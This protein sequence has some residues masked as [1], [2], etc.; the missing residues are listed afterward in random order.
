MVKAIRFHK[1]G[2]PEVMRLEDVDL[3]APA[4]GEVQVKHTAIGLNYIDTYHR[5]GLYPL[6]MPHGLGMEGAGTVAA[7]GGGV[8]DLKVGDRIAYAAPPPGSY[9]EARN[10]EASK[11]VKV[12]DGV[13]DKTAAAMMLKGMTAQYLI[14]Q[15]YKVQSGDTILIHAAAGGVGLIVSQWAKALGA[16]V[17]GTVSSDAKAALA[18]ANGCDHPII[19]TRDNFVEKVL[20]ITGG[21]KLPVVY[22]SIGKDTWPASLDVLRPRGTMVS[23]GQASGPIPP[24]DLGIFAQKG[25]LVF[26]RPTLMTF[27]ATKEGLATMA[28]DLFD[29]VKSGKVKINIE[30]TYALADVVKAH[31]DLEGRK[32]TGSTVLMP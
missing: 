16:T 6:P 29:A 2:G 5:S 19:Y 11:V 1:P 22:D 18:K 25:S 23:F 24:V 8:S 7:V 17:I 32:T 27:T 4:A 21:K 28:N 26:T 20:E 13:D 9:A 10:I 30:Q 31:Q 3:A 12:P 14:R 15:V